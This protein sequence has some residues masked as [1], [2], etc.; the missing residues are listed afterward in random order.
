MLQA[1]TADNA[2]HAFAAQQPRLAKPKVDKISREHVLSPNS[3]TTKLNAS[4]YSIFF[5][6]SI[7]FSLWVGGIS[8]I[9]RGGRFLS[10]Y[11]LLS[12]FFL[13]YFNLSLFLR[14]WC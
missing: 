14:N 9:G 6:S 2:K 4:V 5:H 13:F 8:F 12:V 10:I 1:E 11:K 7:D 3:V